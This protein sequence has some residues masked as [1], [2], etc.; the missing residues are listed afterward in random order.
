MLIS[1]EILTFIANEFKSSIRDMLGV[2]NRIIASSRIQN[3]NPS[4]QDAKLILKDLFSNMNTTVNIEDIQ[5]IVVIFMI[6]L[7]LIFYLLDVQD[8]LQ[9]QDKLQCIYQRN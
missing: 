3:R 1:D 4:L 7:L 8:T 5:K 2:L 6:F 9:D